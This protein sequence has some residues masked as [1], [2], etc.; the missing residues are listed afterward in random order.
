MLQDKGRIEEEEE[1]KEITEGACRAVEAGARAIARI[2]S[3]VTDT[4]V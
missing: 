3:V 1:R 4:S 2:G